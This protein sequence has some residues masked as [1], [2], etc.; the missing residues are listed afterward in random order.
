MSGI[1]KFSSKESVLQS[2]NPNSLFRGCRRLLEGVNV[3]TFR[4]HGMVVCTELVV[5]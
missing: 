2:F 4:N 3:F 1:G 5:S